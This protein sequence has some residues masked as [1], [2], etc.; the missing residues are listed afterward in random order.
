MIAGMFMK[1][2][3]PRDEREG[4]IRL[5]K[6]SLR[7]ESEFLSAARTS[8]ELHKDWVDVPRTARAFRR[9]AI[10]MRTR[11][12]IAFLVRR[13]DTG[14]LVGV[15][16]LQDIFMGNFCNAYVIYYAFSGQ[17]R[18]G[19]MTVAM[20]EVIRIAFGRLKL[21]RLEAN[22][23]PENHASRCLASSC[24]FRKEGFSPKFLK[25]GGEWRDHERWAL[26]STDNLK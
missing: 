3:N 4:R 15:I 16:E 23:Q 22:I 19:L 13:T 5:N 10:E 20:K 9:Y 12:D 18:Q 26:L 24:G 21:H 1:T 2:S 6:V 11:D 8:R 7:D 25:K 14:G 17:E